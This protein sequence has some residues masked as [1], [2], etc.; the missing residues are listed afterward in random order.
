M[1]PRIIIIT[2]LICSSMAYAGEQIT[3]KDLIANQIEERKNLISACKKD[4]EVVSL[5]NDQVN[6]FYQLTQILYSENDSLMEYSSSLCKENAKL[7]DIVNPIKFAMI[8]DSTV[9]NMD[10]PKKELVP[11][12]LVLHYEMIANVINVTKLLKNVDY[13]IKETVSHGIKM[14]LNES[15]IN[16]NIQEAINNDLDNI[17]IALK[18]LKEFE[19]PTFSQ[20]QIEYI[21]KLNNQYN[22][23][24][25]KYFAE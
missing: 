20:Q 25:S 24:N 6:D 14:G 12:S 16:R 15:Q 17:Y 2:T 9:F 3:T 18:D 10:L 4:K 13:K 1:R 22:S 21:T 5:L 19:K 23:I 7:L 11:S 8:Q